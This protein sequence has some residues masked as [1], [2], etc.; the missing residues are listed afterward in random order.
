VLVAFACLCAQPLCAGKATDAALTGGASVPKEGTDLGNVGEK[1]DFTSIEIA[2]TVDDV[3]K[4]SFSYIF[5][6][7]ELPE[8]GGTDYNDAFFLNI[9]GENLA[10]LPDGNVCLFV[11]FRLA[12]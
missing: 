9:N 10:K 11:C 7:R 1:D 3:V 2:L 4:L 12:G 5:A 6:S 8:F